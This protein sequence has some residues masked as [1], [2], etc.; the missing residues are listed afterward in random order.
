MEKILSVTIPTYN[1]EKYLSNCLDSFIYDKDAKDIEI[2]IV[3]DGSK[4]NSLKIAKEY[5]EKYPNIFKVI[6]KENG[7]HGSTINA[8]L[9]A[10]TGKYFKVVDSD[11]WVNTEEFKKLLEFLRKNDVDCVLSDYV[12]QYEASKKSKAIPCDLNDPYKIKNI[13]DVNK[14]V[15]CI[16]CYVFK[17]ET[18]RTNKIQ[19]KCFYVDV[20]YNLF[21]YLKCKTCVY[22]PLNLYQYR[23]GRAGQSVSVDG[24][25]KHRDNHYTVIKNIINFYNAKKDSASEIKKKEMFNYIAGIVVAHYRYYTLMNFKHKDILLELKEFDEWAKQYEDFY[26]TAGND[27]IVK[28]YRKNNFKKI[29]WYKP[30]YNVKQFI[31]KLIGWN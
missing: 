19:E 13:E 14:F 25:Y 5:E 6:D 18:I 2:I 27:I 8:G 30:I 28:K 26:I 11:D 7:G 4:D 12:C 3:N 22:V 29:W 24:L 17:T 15:F 31:K 1:M 23:L 9:K 10:A 20:E 21:S 16:H